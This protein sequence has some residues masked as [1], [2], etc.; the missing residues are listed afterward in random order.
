MPDYFLEDLG[1]IHG[2]VNISD[3]NFL[4]VLTRKQT[5]NFEVQMI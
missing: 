2:S 4:M 5:G 1:T 3:L